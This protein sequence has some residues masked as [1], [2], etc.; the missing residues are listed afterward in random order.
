M[1]GPPSIHAPKFPHSN[2]DNPHG[3]IMA[4]K[5]VADPTTQTPVLK[6][7][8]ISRDFNL[9]DP[10]DLANGGRFCSLDRRECQPGRW[11]RQAAAEHA[12]CHAFRARCEDRKGAL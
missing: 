8:W 9:P 1:G 11:R 3:S 6:P 10:V 12:S 5:V 4:C 7:E 2:G